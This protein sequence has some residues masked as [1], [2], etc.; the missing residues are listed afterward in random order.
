[1]RPE[2][3]NE[4]NIAAF[5]REQGISLAILFGSRATGRI[6]AGSDWDLAVWV[7]DERIL[8]SSL[9]AAGRKR[10]LIRSWCNYLQTGNLDLVILNRATALIKFEVARNG[11]LLYEKESGLFASFCSR[12]LREHNDARLFYQATREYI[13]R[14]AEEWREW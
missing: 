4:K 7:E 9:V 5:C 3:F 6:H 14:V 2:A 10:K 12:A 8:E 13:H 1:M 11:K